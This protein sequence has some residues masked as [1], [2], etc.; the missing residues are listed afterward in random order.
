MSS[1]RNGVLRRDRKRLDTYTTAEEQ[2]RVRELEREAKLDRNRDLEEGL[3]N[4]IPLKDVKLRC[5]QGRPILLGAG[6]YGKVLILAFH[7][8]LCPVE[9]SPVLA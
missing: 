4:R 8:P 3:G 7:H 5:K 9:N 6:G 1:G 2:K